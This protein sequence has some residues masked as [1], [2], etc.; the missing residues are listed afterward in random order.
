MYVTRYGGTVLALECD[1][2]SLCVAGCVT[3]CE[4]VALGPVEELSAFHA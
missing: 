4:S 1:R 2:L 3:V